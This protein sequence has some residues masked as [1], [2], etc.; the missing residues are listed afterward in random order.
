MGEDIAKRYN[1]T[2]L[3]YHIVCQLKYRRDVITK[4]IGESLKEI[5]LQIS[6]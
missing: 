1:K 2:F 4:E 3:L 5:C 6:E